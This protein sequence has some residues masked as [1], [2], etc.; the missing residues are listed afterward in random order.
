MV[1]IE[2]IRF[3]DLAGIN[4]LKGLPLR[5]LRPPIVVGNITGLG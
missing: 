4:Q 5:Q 2:K 3:E 1:Q